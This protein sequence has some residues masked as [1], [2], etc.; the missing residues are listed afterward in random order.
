MIPA[1]ISRRWARAL[2]ELAQEENRLEAVAE[3][4]QQLAQLS[5]SHGEIQQL[6]LNPAFSTASQKAVFA[7]ILQKMG[8]DDLL[9][10][11]VSVLIEKDRLAA[12]GGI[13]KAA[14]DLTD[15]ALGRRR[16]LVT[17]ARPLT[18]EQRTQLKAS[19]GQRT[20]A[21]IVMEEEVNE[22]LVAGLRVQ[23][24]SQRLESSVAGHFAQLQRDLGVR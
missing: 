23:L 17:S 1:S 5:Q 9:K 7:E 21:E 19:L 6:I 12:L 14:Q 24:G 15:R 2:V 11:F 18:E 4:L 22:D 13:A 16:A 20:G 8:A 10:R 3:Q